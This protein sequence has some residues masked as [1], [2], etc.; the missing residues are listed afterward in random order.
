MKECPICKK[1]FSKSVLKIHLE[2]CKSKK[3]KKSEIKKL[4][5]YT[6]KELKAMCKEKGLSG[7]SNL[8]EKELIELLEG[9]E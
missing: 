2:H 8:K 6:V 5:D 9:V 1:Q 7:Y 4:S 3:E